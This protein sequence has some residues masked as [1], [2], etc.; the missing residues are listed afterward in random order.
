MAWMGKGKGTKSQDQSGDPALKSR[1]KK[2]LRMA[3][4][5]FP[6]LLYL[7]F[8]C[9]L[10]PVSEFFCYKMTEKQTLAGIV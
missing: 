10:T 4:R 5:C 2:E 3:R 8:F 7:Y 6:S 9:C 1:E